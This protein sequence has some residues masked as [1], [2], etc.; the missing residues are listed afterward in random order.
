M[1]KK[2]KIIILAVLVSVAIVSA[3]GIYYE[4]KSS[5]E[6]GNVSDNVPSEKEKILSSDDE[7]GFQE[8]VAEIIKTKDFS[9]C[10]KISN[11]TYRKVCVNNIALDLAQEKGDVSYCAELDGNMVSVSECERGIV[12]AKSASE[13]NMEICKQATT[14]EVASECESGFYQAVS[15]KKED[16]GY[17]DNIG[18]QKATDE[19]YDNFVFSME[20]M[21]DIKNFKCSSFRNQDLANDCLAYKNMKSDQE[22]D[23]SGYKSSQYMDLCLMRIYNYFSK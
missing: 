8:Q 9:H 18:D 13:E 5:R 6:T 4:S 10:E 21:K 17:C 7:I 11:D 15:L 16:K 22:P 1:Q 3:A 19:C 14:K 2:T 12:L 20:F 23:C